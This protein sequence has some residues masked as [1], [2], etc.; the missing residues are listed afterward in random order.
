MDLDLQKQHD[1]FIR[2]WWY[3]ESNPI[4][5]AMNANCSKPQEQPNTLEETKALFDAEYDVEDIA[6]RARGLTTVIVSRI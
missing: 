5:P 4:L 6:I 2:R 3:L 1:A